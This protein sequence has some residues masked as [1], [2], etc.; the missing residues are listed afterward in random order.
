VARNNVSELWVQAQH[1]GALVRVPTGQLPAVPE[2]GVMAWA[3]RAPVSAST[4]IMGG[5]AMA[6][7]GGL[8]AVINPFG[9]VGV[10][11]FGGMITFGGGIAWLGGVKARAA[12][13]PAPTS[14]VDPRVLAERARR[15]SAVLAQLGQ[16]TYE[17]LLGRLRWTEQALI[18][19]LVHMKDRAVV[20]E[21]LDLDTGEWVYRMQ[22]G[23]DMG[24]RGSMMLDERAQ[25]RDRQSERA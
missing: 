11:I 10:A 15:V 23:E 12:A 19:T 13:R 25:L 2:S 14:S 16:A 1:P 9:F 6:L 4:M 22:H 18:E 24:T 21:D 8:L 20:V 5:V 17:T 7:V 3:E